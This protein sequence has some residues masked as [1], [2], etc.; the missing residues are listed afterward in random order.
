MQREIMEGWRGVETWHF[1]DAAIEGVGQSWCTA[2]QMAAGL[3][4]VGRINRLALLA[5]TRG[6]FI[7]LLS[8][9]SITSLCFLFSF[10][11]CLLF[12]CN[13]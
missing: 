2:V 7:A 5:F 11:A 6:N 1:G 13:S 3:A 10:F 12:P 8:A 9:E 4:V